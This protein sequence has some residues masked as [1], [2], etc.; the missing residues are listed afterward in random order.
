MLPI[1]V[2]W[3]VVRLP[4]PHFA[5]DRPV[6]AASSER[7][8]HRYLRSATSQPSRTREPAQR[9]RRTADRPVEVYLAVEADDAVGVFGDGLQVVFDEEDG[10]SLVVQRFEES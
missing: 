6:D 5:G 3:F 1:S 4:V 10:D 7:K 2:I 9:F 8:R